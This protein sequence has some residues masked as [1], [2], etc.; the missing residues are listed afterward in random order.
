M[1]F[2]VNAD[3]RS[4]A[5][6]LLFA[7]AFGASVTVLESIETA[8]MG[9]AAVKQFRAAGLETELIERPGHWLHALRVVTRAYK[10]DLVIVGRMWMRGV[11]RFLFGSIPPALFSDLRTNLLIVRHSRGEIKRVLLA[12]GGGP[13]G[14]QVLRWGGLVAHAF[15]AQPVL[16]HVTAELPGMFFGLASR[17]ESLTQFMRSNTAEARRFQLARDTLHLLEIEPE[18]KLGYGE[19]MEEVIQEARADKSD[20]IV[21][22]SSYAG[23]PTARFLAEPVTDRIVQRAPCP[24]LVVRDIIDP[25]IFTR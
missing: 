9:A 21:V 15:D 22:G 3:E 8:G 2:L 14:R 4:V 16:Y 13:T 1:R 5:L 7:R 24:V 6:G 12:L 17:R 20:L 10:Y 18:L 25:G 19:V 23:P 11:R